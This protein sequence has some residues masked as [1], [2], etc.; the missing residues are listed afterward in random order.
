MLRSEYA[1]RLCPDVSG[2]DSGCHV[3]GVIMSNPALLE[4]MRSLGYE[5]GKLGYTPAMVECL[6]DFFDKN[7]K[8]RKPQLSSVK[9]K[10]RS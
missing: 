1:R 2:K 6:N 10:R 4:K 7:P 5:P 3:A 8:L 9:K